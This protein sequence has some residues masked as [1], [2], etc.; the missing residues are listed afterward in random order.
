MGLARPLTFGPDEMLDLKDIVLGGKYET[1]PGGKYTFVPDMADRYIKEL[2][3]RPKL[4][5][6][7]KVVAACGNG[8][9]GAFAPK[10]LQAVGCE[11]VPLHAELD[12][13][14]PHYNPNPEDLAMLHDVSAKVLEVGA[15]VGLAFDG[16]GDRCGSSITKAKRFFPT[17]S[18]S[19]WLAISPPHTKVQSSLP[20]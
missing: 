17:R 19:C 7:L 11:V 15:D 20:M 16:D 6:S 10:V 8:T 12:H 2:T 3:D 4:K 14:F 1:A 18:A 13:S 9:A 5:R